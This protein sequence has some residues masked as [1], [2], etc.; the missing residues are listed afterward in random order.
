MGVGQAR[1]E[2]LLATKRLEFERVKTESL[3]RLIALCRIVAPADGKV[4][5]SFAVAGQIVRHGQPLVTIEPTVES[6]QRK[7]P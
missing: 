4:V 5:S 1:N 7:A 2:L 6:G 3:E